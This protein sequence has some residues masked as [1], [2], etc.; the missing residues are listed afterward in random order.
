MTATGRVIGLGEVLLR[1]KS[2]GHE[3]LLQSPSLEATFGGAEANVVA[4]LAQFGVPTSFV[5]A[6]PANPIGDAALSALR[7][8]G[9]DS[10]AV[11]R[12]GERVGV[13]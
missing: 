8:F 11:V 3:R 2:P 9:I 10:S 7:A 6:L 5:T 13:Y 4:S 1:L 12:S